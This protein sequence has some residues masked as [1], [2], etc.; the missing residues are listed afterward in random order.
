[1]PAPQFPC[2]GWCENGELS[3]TRAN[4][5]YCSAALVRPLAWSQGHFTIIMRSVSM[6][7][8]PAVLVVVAGCEQRGPFVYV[9]ESPQSV[10]LTAYASPSKVQQG[11]T[12]VLH[13]KRRTSGKWKQVSRDEVT[14]GQCWVYRPPAEVEPE[15][16][17][18]VQWEVAPAGAAEFHTAYQL[19]QTRVATM[20]TK[21]KVKLTP[22]SA[23]KCEDDRS[24][25]GPSIDI[26]VS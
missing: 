22:I 20:T 15:V 26:E 7:L 1:L 3:P 8:I 23:V 13:V 25:E 4:V 2:L 6:L 16:A 18:S 10:V 17:H 11:E 19:D 21:G 9:L 14:P 12:V 5:G 24:V